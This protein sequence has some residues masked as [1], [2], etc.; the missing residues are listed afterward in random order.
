MPSVSVREGVNL[1]CSIMLTRADPRRTLPETG[2]GRLQSEP[3]RAA[4]MRNPGIGTCEEIEFPFF[5]GDRKCIA[6]CQTSL[7]GHLIARF[8]E[9]QISLFQKINFFTCSR[10]DV[11]PFSE[12]APQEHRNLTLPETYNDLSSNHA[13]SHQCRRTNFSFDGGQ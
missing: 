8:L 1:R 3:T 5:A 13:R 2:H 9:A 4:P 6:K 7:V 11:S 12:V 10:R